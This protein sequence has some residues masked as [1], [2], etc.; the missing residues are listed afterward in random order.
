MQVFTEEHAFA[1]PRGVIAWY[2]MT[3]KVL[4]LYTRPGTLPS[5]VPPCRSLQDQQ[6][7]AINGETDGRGDSTFHAYS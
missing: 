1:K 4:R 3:P 6:Y 2:G 5:A 7:C